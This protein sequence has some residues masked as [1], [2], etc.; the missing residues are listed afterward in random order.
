MLRSCVR[1]NFL[2]QWPLRAVGHSRRLLSTPPAQIPPVTHI[3]KIIMD[4]IK[5]TGP[6]SVSTYM[7]LCL[8]HPTLGYYM[9]PHN[10]V[11]GSSGDFITSPE[12][13][14]IF[15]EMLGVWLMSQWQQS[16]QLPI[17]VIE[18]GPGRGTL[19]YDVLRVLG[20]FARNKLKSVHLV[21]TSPT[22]RAL[23]RKIL[24]SPAEK[25]GCTLEWHDSIEQISPNSEEYTMFIAHEFFDALPI[26]VI[27]KTDEG[28]QEL[29]VALAES[30][31]EGDPY[32][33]LRYVM[34]PPT[35]ASTVLGLSSKRFST[36]GGGLRIEVSPSSFKTM[37]K[38]GTLI[39]GEPA[40][41]DES[42][43]SSRGCG[44]IV[45][46]GDTRVFK[47][48]FRAFKSHEIVDPFHMPGEC[49]LTA[50][51]DF[52][53][54]KEAVDDIVTVHGP[55]PQAAFLE[56]MGLQI[57]IEQQIFDSSD[58][59]ERAAI[60]QV[61]HR[62]INPTGMGREYMVMGITG[63]GRGEENFWPFS[64]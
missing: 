6:I 45:D 63:H 59:D 7:Q 3:E 60:R 27:E 5:A 20:R 35:A 54:L 13:S 44:L 28:W 57:R 43:P 51:V 22:M 36:L 48:S 17:R 18:L 23:Q 9:N 21:E 53:Y 8:S 1:R 37:R 15:G 52:S 41:I 26:H 40:A 46:Y 24:S 42:Q 14:S 2:F 50:N 49:D 25:Y 64:T 56:G 47:R 39:R 34:A 38:L 4:G 30:D 16:S 29:L 62:L 55:I 19:M 32:P 11:F 61:G 10:P 31:S 12:I 33:R 58:D